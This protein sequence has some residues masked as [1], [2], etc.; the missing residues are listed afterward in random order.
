MQTEKAGLTRKEKRLLTAAA[1]LGIFY[2]AFQFGFQPF[3]TQYNEKTE[4]YDELSAEWQEIEARLNEEDR[5]RREH[6]DAK[7]AYEK[8]VARFEQSDADTDLSRMLTDYSRDNGFINPSQSLG[9]PVNFEIPGEGSGGENSFSTVTA[10]MTFFGNVNNADYGIIGY[11]ELKSLADAIKA[12]RDVRI[13]RVTFSVDS[14]RPVA[15]TFVVTLLNAL[16]PA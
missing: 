9:E 7:A 12:N 3:Y 6:Q 2:L 5:V 16:E 10:T 13:S 4:R 14:N 8:I 1:V 15:V 11:R